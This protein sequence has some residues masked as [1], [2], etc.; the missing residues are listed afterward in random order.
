MIKEYKLQYNKQ[1]QEFRL[2]KRE[3]G[4]WKHIPH[5]G[6]HWFKNRAEAAAL[7]KMRQFEAERSVRYESEN[8]EE[9]DA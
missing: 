5:Q 8:W 9:F 6:I 1:L 2:V 4:M 7:N 3:N